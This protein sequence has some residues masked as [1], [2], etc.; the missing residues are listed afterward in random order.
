M[1]ALE[2]HLARHWGVIRARDL[3]SLGVGPRELR[4]LIGAGCWCGALAA[5]T[6]R[7]PPSATWCTPPG[8]SPR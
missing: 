6:R 5:S 4:R 1:G 3:R 7:R 2:I 8:A